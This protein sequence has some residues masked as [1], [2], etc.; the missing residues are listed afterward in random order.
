M[1]VIAISRRAP[2][3]WVMKR[4]TLATLIELTQPY[5]DNPSDRC[6]LEERQRATCG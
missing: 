3:A 5:L 2:D 6:E 4:R 1:A